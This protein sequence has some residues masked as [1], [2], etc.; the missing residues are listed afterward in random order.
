MRGSVL[1]ELAAPGQCTC[2]DLTGVRV[3][4]N[5]RADAFSPPFGGCAFVPR[6]LFLNGLVLPRQKLSNM[7]GAMPTVKTAPI[8]V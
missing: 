8:T 5:A 3:Q 2:L 1:S 6:A 7:P 4:R